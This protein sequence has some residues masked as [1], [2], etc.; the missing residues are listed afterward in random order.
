MEKTAI[1]INSGLGDL[2]IGLEMAGFK[3]VAA[4]EADQ[5]AVA[6]HRANLNVP[7]FP[8]PFEKTSI[9]TVP[10]DLL[11]SRIYQPPLSR[12]RFS[13]QK[14][15]R[16]TVY[17]FLA[18]L[19]ICRPQAFFITSHSSFIKSE[20][21]RILLNEVAEKE[22]QCSYRILNVAQITGAPVMERMACIVGSKSP[23]Q[24]KFE[25]L[26]ESFSRPLQ[27]ELFLQTAEQIDAWYFKIPSKP[28]EFPACQ[29]RTCFCCW[30]SHSYEE[31]QILRWNYWKIPL[32]HTREGFRKITHR[33][34]A[35]LKEFPSSYVLSDCKNRSWLYQKLMYAANVQVIKQIAD[36]LFHD[37]TKPPVQ[38]LSIPPAIQFENL[39]SRY[40]KKIENGADIKII[41]P[42]RDSGYDFEFK[43]NDQTLYFDLKCYR[44]RRVPAS[45][46]RIPS[47]KF[48]L[49]SK[50]GRPV[51]VFANEVSSQI[52]LNYLEKH[53]ILIWDVQNLL[54]LFQEFED[55][56]SEFIALLDYSVSDIE[57]VPPDPNVFQEVQSRDLNFSQESSSETVPE[58]EAEI[59][60][61]TETEANFREKQRVLAWEEKLQGIKPGQ[62]QFQ[63]YEQ[64][65]IDILKYT[66]GSYLT[67]WEQQA[68]TDEGL[69]R[70]DLCCKIKNGVQH[71]FFH[72]ITHFFYSK[73]IVFEFK[74]H[75]D[76]ITQK[77]IYTTEK[78][79]YGTALRKVAIIISR[80]GYDD[81]A[82]RAVKG[83]LRESGKL[84]MCL[85]DRDLLK[86]AD[87]KTH[88]DEPADF[89]DELL[90]SILVHLE[91]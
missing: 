89:L 67:L 74:N 49:L 37:L 79:L 83:S 39:F 22:Y 76:K 6:I 62:E 46:I 26:R 30:K 69:H 55:I 14:D 58:V 13:E 57:P 73:Y 40:L 47:I 72:T 51:L 15:S 42:S 54:W 16:A 18:F 33:E 43:M 34:I 44:G 23:L 8:L 52:K 17:D 10:C 84:I 68:S 65:C 85:A 87:S 90:D 41:S 61:K 78:Y 28:E 75:A 53:H 88:G 50:S 60:T 25:F 86:M 80:Q 19:D 32:I 2:S 77:E 1:V 7:V 12:G 20:Q 9:K 36:I 48:S 59:P 11:V 91:K 82:L 70:F 45:S 27:P 3:V 81:N 56:K 31:T 35:N 24:G 66:L 64:A 71:G 63:E 38:E 21:F 29:D 4:Y 5:K